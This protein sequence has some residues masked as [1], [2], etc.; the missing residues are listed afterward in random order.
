MNKT[1]KR[2]LIIAGILLALLF[3]VGG[4]FI[5]KNWHKYV[6]NKPQMYAYD[7]FRGDS[8]P[9]SVLII[10]DIDLKEPYLKYYNELESGIE[11]ILDNRIPLKGLPQYDPIYILQYTDDSLLVEV[12]SYY[13]RGTRFGGSYTQGWIYSKTLYEKPFEKKK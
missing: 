5:N 2:I 4:Y 1:I 6:K 10:E 8:K 3:T 12:V 11:P 7:I 9:V 13:D